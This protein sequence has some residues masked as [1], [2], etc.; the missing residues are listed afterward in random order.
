MIKNEPQPGVVVRWSG[1]SRSQRRPSSCCRGK[2]LQPSPRASLPNY[3]TPTPFRVRHHHADGV[4]QHYLIH[5][6]STA[7]ICIAT[8]ATL[9]TT[10]YVFLRTHFC[11]EFQVLLVG[12]TSVCTASRM[13][14]K[15]DVCR[16]KVGRECSAKVDHNILT[17]GV[18][19]LPLCQ[20][21]MLKTWVHKSSNSGKKVTNMSYYV[22][23][24]AITFVSLPHLIEKSNT[25]FLFSH[26]P[27]CVMPSLYEWRCRVLVVYL[28][29]TARTF[30]YEGRGFQYPHRYCYQC[31]PS[32]AKTG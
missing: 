1:W 11:W 12:N 4:A 5:L 8:S 26:R 10:A 31:V 2:K 17:F 27:I 22:S 25:Y 18:R 3:R 20:P 23:I 21:V 32:V 29:S 13:I 19:W 7:S 15:T 30:N 14:E 24:D 6:E 9:I 16:K 28:I